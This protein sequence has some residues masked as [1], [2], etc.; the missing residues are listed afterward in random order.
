MAKKTFV[1]VVE[2]DK[3]AD[4]QQFYEQTRTLDPVMNGIASVGLPQL[5]WRAAKGK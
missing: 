1:V 4:A 2:F 5:L 3:A